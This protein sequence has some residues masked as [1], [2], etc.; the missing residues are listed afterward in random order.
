MIFQPVIAG[1][2]LPSL[3]SP[4]SA[5]D[6]LTGKE[7]IDAEGNVLTGT[8]PSVSHPAPTISVSSAGLI[9][10]SHAQS[11]GKVEAGTTQAT[12]QLTAQAGKTVTPGTTQQTAVASGRYTTGAVYVAGDADL[13]AANIKSGVNIFGVT[14]TYA[15]A[16]TIRVRSASITRNSSTKITITHSET[17]PSGY[18]LDS[19]YLWIQDSLEDYIEQIFFTHYYANYTGVIAVPI[20]STRYSVETD[21]SAKDCVTISGSSI[22]IDLGNW[23]SSNCKFQSGNIVPFQFSAYY[24]TL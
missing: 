24:S 3:T 14:G 8:M 6:L 7:L 12:R 19:L 20:S 22:V 11:E 15:G 18:T 1:K 17:I 16:T 2:K 9:T 21:A 23:Y 10:A 4:G 13:V 5:A